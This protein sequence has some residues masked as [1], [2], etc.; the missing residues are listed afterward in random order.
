MDLRE[1]AQS[2]MKIVFLD[3]DGVINSSIFF[4]KRKLDE[5]LRMG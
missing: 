1:A 5:S 3:F 4:N 2:M